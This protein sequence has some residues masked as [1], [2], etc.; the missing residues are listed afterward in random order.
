[1]PDGQRVGD[2]PGLELTFS[3]CVCELDHVHEQFGELTDG[4]LQL[5]R[6]AFVRFPPVRHHRAP[7][8]HTHPDA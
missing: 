1:M 7:L 4:S 6:A 2:A 5:G 8:A 3:R